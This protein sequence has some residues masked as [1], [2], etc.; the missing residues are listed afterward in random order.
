MNRVA[1]I[2]LAAL[3]A[4][5]LGACATRKTPAPVVD[6]RLPKSAT[7][8][9]GAV[10][11]PPVPT[12]A[13]PRRVEP[14]PGADYYTVQR[15]DTLYSIALEHG[16]DY[17]EVAQWNHLD[18]PTRIRIGQQL[19]VTPPPAEAKAQVGPARIPGRVEARPLESRPLE[20]V[21][22][23]A[24]SAKLEPRPEP[25]AEPRPEPKTEARGEPPAGDF[26]WPVRGRV[27]AEF[28]EP[29][30]KGIDIE[31]RPGDPVVAA[32]AGRVTYSGTG[33][34]GMGKLIVIKHPNGYIT[35]YAHNRD[36]LVKE[37]QEVN[38]GQ[39]I[40][41]A[42]ASDAERPKLHFQ[43]RKG[44]AAVDPLLYLPKS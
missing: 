35:V 39:K 29:R 16:A 19:R 17:R 24:P 8:K 43:I 22:G 9:P 14:K 15:G 38:R 30:R 31:A 3:L 41:E 4:L 6:A 25:R 37:Q 34:P 36:I 32:A 10:V 1:L 18:D 13:P 5:L 12:A 28:S 7:V 20:S 27:L 21:P 11:P 40:A 33:I 42:G 26:V 2:A 23:P 44:A